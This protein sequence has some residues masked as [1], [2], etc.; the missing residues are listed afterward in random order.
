MSRQGDLRLG[1]SFP[2]H[3]VCR[4]AI[5]L[6]GALQALLARHT[7]NVDGLSYLDVAA[8][9]LK[10]NTAEAIN[11]Y[12]SPLYSWLIAAALWLADPSPRWE[13]AT[14]HAV[15][16]VV[17]GS[18]LVAFEFFLRELFR[19]ASVGP[20]DGTAR[21][22]TEWW[23][24]GY[25]CF[26]YASLVLLTL[27]HV[28][29]DLLLSAA[30]YVVAA[31]M[32]RLSRAS[33]APVKLAGLLGAVIGLGYLSKAVMLPLGA[34]TLAV[35]VVGMRD[36]RAKLM[37]PL[38]AVIA[39]IC[40]SAPWVTAL[41]ESKGRFTTGDSGK[42]NFAWRVEGVRLFR[43]WQGDSLTG[44]PLHATRP[45]SRNPSIY[46]FRA[47]I[48]GTYPIW[49]DPSYW[50]DGVRRQ[51][52]MRTQARRL[53]QS[54]EDFLDQ[55][56]FY[57]ATVA[58]VAAWFLAGFR[59]SATALS[60][61][62]LV[63]ILMAAGFGVYAVVLLIPRYL[64]PFVAITI[65][66]LL[67]AA[68]FQRDGK[69]VWHDRQIGAIAVSLA[70]VLMIM[71]ISQLAFSDRRISRGHPQLDLARAMEPAGVRRG[72][73]VGVIGESSDAYWARLAGA[74]VV[75]EITPEE[76]LDFWAGS[77]ALKA[78][79]LEQFRRAGVV[80]VV[81][82]QVPPWANT[83]GWTSLGNNGYWINSFSGP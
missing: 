83:V 9:Y 12:W 47:P 15:N 75:A 32:L 25:A 46:E 80:A 24:L 18:A 13:F 69:S 57:P 68:A 40:V 50:Y 16:F 53:V 30:I 52:D 21:S 6:L 72:A 77:P 29:P 60:S 49:Y 5:V 42:L 78:A 26:S 23:L 73:E 76:N 28:G 14:V 33:G 37:C 51:G 1:R 79:V 48:A 31:L 66:T 55:Q 54:T 11:A 35:L 2:Y 62:W 22:G 59:R 64:A 34:V 19:T 71:V 17:F 3:W 81:A 8:E 4:S 45:L 38:V 58:I 44:S 10:G 20:E 63:L 82:N 61:T 70:G 41:S 36:R 56:W 43:H 65:P 74:R 39:F 67:L 27:G 7:M